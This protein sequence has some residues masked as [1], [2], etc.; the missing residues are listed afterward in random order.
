[1]LRTAVAARL[2]ESHI[3]QHMTAERVRVDGEPVT[4][5]DTLAP[6]TRVVIWTE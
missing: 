2:S 5:L 3:E 1:M 4:D 6:G